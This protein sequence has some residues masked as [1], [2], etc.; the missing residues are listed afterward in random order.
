MVDFQKG[1][2]RLILAGD[3][4]DRGPDSHGVVQRAIELGAEAV[5]GNHDEAHVRWH[6]HELKKRDDPTYRNPMRPLNEYRART[7]SSLTDEDFVY[8]NSLPS[9]IRIGT[10]AIVVHGGLLPDYPERQSQH[11]MIRRRWVD[12]VTKKSTP[13]GRKHEVPAGSVFW[14]SFWNGPETVYYGHNVGNLESP[15]VTWDLRG[16]LTVGLDTGAC[17]GGHLTAAII[18]RD[19]LLGFTKIKSQK[20]VDYAIW[21]SKMPGEPD[22]IG[23]HE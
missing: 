17:F 2:D 10:T 20:Y 7:Q 18:D 19:F 11:D 23:T 15:V 22:T 8:L 9:F 4:V 16:P 13:L 5:M 21:K 14:T 6:N 1:R 3:L 12:P